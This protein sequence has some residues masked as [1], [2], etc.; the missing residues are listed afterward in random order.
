MDRKWLSIL[1][2]LAVFLL[3]FTYIKVTKV[4]TPLSLDVSPFPSPVFLKQCRDLDFKQGR[5]IKEE[6]DLY[7][8]DLRWENTMI[9]VGHN[10][11]CH[12]ILQNQTES[13]KPDHCVIDHLSDLQFQSILW[14][15]TFVFLGDSLTENF[16]F[17]WTYHV[18]VKRHLSQ[19]SDWRASTYGHQVD[20]LAYKSSY[21]MAGHGHTTPLYLV[22]E[23]LVKSLRK[24]HDVIL[25]NTGI[26]W[27]RPLLEEHLLNFTRKYD[28]LYDSLPLVWWKDTTPQH[29]SSSTG[30]FE[31]FQ[32]ATTCKND[33]TSEEDKKQYYHVVTDHL[34]S[35]RSRERRIPM[36][37]T[38]LAD[39]QRG[40][41]HLFGNRRNRHNVIDCTHW[42]IP[43]SVTE[44]WVAIFAHE[45]YHLLENKEKKE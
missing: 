15:R 40:Q 20:S 16:Y 11:C 43:S 30:L 1:Y 10:C 6:E 14:N 4:D 39:A 23:R 45:V 12:H 18:Y 35:N 31:G 9:P 44:N 33:L 34:F 26:H 19:R 38:F 22:F 32:N 29:F 42:C 13:W 21:E 7:P 28:Q 41:Q 17:A 36:I 27:P 24:G 5:W 37:S 8:S 2:F 3:F 25:L